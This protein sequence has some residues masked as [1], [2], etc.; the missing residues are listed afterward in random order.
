MNH[1]ITTA[2]ILLAGSAVLAYAQSPTQESQPATVTNEQSCQLPALQQ[3]PKLH[4]GK[5]ENGLSYM[6]RPTTEPAGR[7]SI[8]L[9]VDTGSLDEA[10]ETS[11]VAH[12]LEHLV[13]NGSRHYKRG[14]LIPKMQKLGLG[15]GGDAN[16]YTSLLHTVY[17]LDL[18]NLNEETVDFAFTIMRDFADGATL[19]DEAIDK[20]RGIVISELKARD[21][22]QYRAMIGL[23]RLMTEGTRVADYMPIGREE[24]IRNISYQAVRDYY[25]SHYV[26]E[27]MTLII[28]GDVTPQ[29]AEEW[30]RKYFGSM[31]KSA[32]L[33]RPSIGELTNT[34][35]LE[36]LISNKEQADSSILLVV[37]NAWERR[38]DTIEQRIQDF[39][40]Q[41]AIAMFDRRMERIVRRADAPFQGA[42]IGKESIFRAAEPFTLNTS[43]TPEKWEEALTAAVC[44]LRKAIQYGFSETEI[45]E[46]LQTLQGRLAHANKTWGSIAAGAMADALI[47]SLDEEKLLTTPE[48]D[49]RV[50]R[51]AAEQISKDPDL[52]RKEL[53]KAFRAQDVKLL[54]SGT[55]PDGIDADTFRAA[56]NKAM[57]LT[58]EKPEAKEAATFAYENIGA[59][60]TVVSQETLEDIGVTTL[61][62]SNGI[63]VNLKP[64][65]FMEGSICVSAAVDGGYMQHEHLKPGLHTFVDP[66]MNQGGLEAHSADELESILAGKQVGDSFAASQDRFTY[67]GTT[68]ANDFELQCKLLAACISHPGFRADGETVLRRRI[69][70]FYTRLETTPEGAYNMQMPRALFGE[71]VRFVLPK[72]EEL[73]SITTEDVKATVQKAL[74]SGAMEVTIIGDFKV[75]DVLPIIMRTFGAMPQRNTEFTKI[76]DAAR[77]VTFQPWGQRKFLYFDTQLDK[78]LV[79]QIRPAGNGMDYR[80][81]RRLQVL[82]SIVREKL[83]DGLRAVLG[84]SYS[85]SVRLILN[86]DFKNAAYISATSAGVQ[87]NREKVSAAMESICNGIGQGNITDEDVERALRPIITASEKNLRTAAYW[88]NNLAKLQSDTT[89][90]E[91]IRDQQ[92]DLQ[93]ISADEIREL[94]KEIYGKDNANF[95]FTVPKENDSAKDT[96][97]APTVKMN[98]NEY[99]VIITEATAA[100][101]E[102]KQVADTLVAKYPGAE[103]RVVPSFTQEYCEKALQETDARYAAY[104]ARPEETGR[105]ATNAFHRAARRV[106]NDPWGD[107]MWGVITGYDAADAQR[108]ADAKDPLIIKRMLG[109]TNVHY[110]PFEHSYCITDWHGSPIMVQDGY[111]EP[112]SRMVEPESAEG[113]AGMQHLF[114]MELS[115]QKPQLL[116]TSSHA[117]QYN[118]EMPF[119]RGLIFSSGNKFHLLPETQMLHFKK[120]LKETME[121]NA[122]SLASLAADG[123]LDTI[124]PDG[125]TRVWLAAGNCLFGDTNGTKESMAV[126]ALSGYTC[127]QVVGYTVPSWFGEGGWGTLSMFL[128]NTTGTTL[129]EAWFLNNQFI[130]RKTM[131]IDEKLLNAEFNDESISYQFQISLNNSGAI[132]SPD[133]AQEAVGLVYDRDTVAFYGDP[134]W[135]A[136]I[137]STHAPAPYTVTWVDN[138]QL[139]ISANADTKGRCAIWFP[140]ADVAHGCTKCNIEGAILTDDFVLIPELEMKKGEQKTIMFK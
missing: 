65:D 31:E 93:S 43:V 25:R 67:S 127:N 12:F 101:P 99:T 68:N 107:C 92:K 50:L 1:S 6:I 49:M 94:A 90:L 95:F 26:P 132:I 53:E 138:N 17:K 28:T 59:P 42:A 135:S 37:P 61:V 131:E 123:Q 102:W 58:V 36:T 128:N 64:A 130:L 18:P 77:S 63:K 40:M 60:G 126:T 75:D 105:I 82:T 81:N 69:D 3:D 10:E 115:T 11:G 104:V 100:I 73:E 116:V 133:N 55:L 78:T 39:P 35:T 109:T 56:F 140:N 86:P 21:S 23:L 16:A 118:L 38:A 51:L 45:R 52:C 57:Q 19:E 70:S 14:E 27:R 44:E 96:H 119:G 34:P 48:E 24:V 108:I 114:G 112:K 89:K 113:K 30:T 137:D 8:R 62:L 72:R 91:M 79:T 136:S 32:P 88:I 7:V 103:L 111:Q 54:L 129:A 124:A 20:E 122:Q 5:L 71:D 120:T 47:D 87:G 106:D 2:L 139:T 9:F 97:P 29:Q 33:P 15:F 83:F 121:G 110:A 84:E 80:R 46:A 117:T 41:L 4:I 125:T 74:Q 134:A 98:G 13:F 76:D 66:V 85:P 22:E